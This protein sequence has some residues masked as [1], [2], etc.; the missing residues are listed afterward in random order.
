MVYIPEEMRVV[1]GMA[2]FGNRPVEKAIDSLIKQVDEIILY[3][4]RLRPDLADNGKF[5]ALTQLTEPCF[6]ISADDDILYP[7]GYV[8]NLREGV[9]RTGC[10]V[11]HH[12]R[13]LADKGVPY[14]TGHRYVHFQKANK[15]LGL[16]DVCGTG[17][18]AFRTD[19]FNPVGIHLAEDKRMVDL[20]FSLEAKK[21]GKEIRALEHGSDW[22]KQLP[23]DKATSCFGIMKQRQERLIELADKIID[24]KG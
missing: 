1:V 20:L 15:Y 7:E 17:V 2:T 9:E 3:D 14:Y 10:I 22:L 23:M 13:I 6:F 12:G 24:L 16:L 21:Q 11:T 18:T 5:Q 8:D 19:Y 4:N